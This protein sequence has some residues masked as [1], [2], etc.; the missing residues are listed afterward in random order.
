VSGFVKSNEDE[1][2]RQVRETSAVRQEQTAKAH[3]WRI[4]KEQK[5]VAELNTLIRKI[6]EDKVSGSLSEKRFEI[7]SAEYED[8]QAALEQSI[9][10]LQAELNGFNADSVRADRFIEI[11]KRH[12]DFSEL[13]APMINEFIEKIVV[14]AADRSS[15]EREQQVDVYLN[16]I[17][18][19]EVPEVTPAP[20]GIAAEEQAR[21][22][23]AHHREAQRRYAEK[24]QGV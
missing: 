13:T 11:V 24:Q 8:E 2:I 4:A 19:F 7:L 3:R 17:G 16:F 18:R 10:R 5:R 22:K 21:E 1:F 9:E 15:G 23:R 6:Y 20:E 12:T 14:H